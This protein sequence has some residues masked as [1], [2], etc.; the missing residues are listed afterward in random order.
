VRRDDDDRAL[1]LLRQA[2]ENGFKDAA[3]I[4]ENP[5]FQPLRGSEE[6]Q[7]LLIDIETKNED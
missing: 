5:N 3:M 1:A 4:K 2:V 6:F 7:R